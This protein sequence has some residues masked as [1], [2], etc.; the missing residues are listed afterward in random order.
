MDVAS[1]MVDEGRDMNSLAEHL[2]TMVSTQS[3]SEAGSSVRSNASKALLT[4]VFNTSL[5]RHMSNVPSVS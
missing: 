1:S 5:K 4:R 3:S 2:C